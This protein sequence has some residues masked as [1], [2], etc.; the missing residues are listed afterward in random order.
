VTLRRPLRRICD[1]LPTAITATSVL[2]MSAPAAFAAEGSAGPSE[3]IFVLQLVAL[4]LVGRL[5][6]EAL[7]R[8]GQP[9]V[10][11]QLMAGLLL[12][13][14]LLGALFP[15]VQ[16]TLFPGAKEQKAMLDGMSQFGVLLILLLTGMETDLELVKKSG[17]ASI[18]ASIAGIIVPFA[19]GFALGEFLPDAMLPD[20]SKRLITSLFLGT[21]L[22]IA[23]VKIVATVVREMNF[24]RRTVG[25]VILGSAIVDDTIGWIIIAVI[26]GLA[27]KGHVDRLS[28]AQ[29]VIGTLVF[30]AFSLTIGRRI[31][32]FIIRW[33]NDTFVSELAVIT[34][35]LLIMGA[36]ALATHAIGVHSVLGAFVAGILV[37]ESPI[38]TKHIDEQLRGLIVAFFM[39]VFF[40]TAGL[41]ADL[42]VL[43]DPNLLML[44]VGLILI[45]TIGKFGGAFLGAEFGGLNRREALALATGMN[46]RGST[47]VIVATIGLSMGALSQDLF[48]MIVIMAVLTTLAM[49]PTLRWALAR[50]PMR[51]DEK[52]RLEREEQAAKG[53]VP[54]LE[55][56][57]V[58]VDDSANGRLAARVAGIVAGTTAMPTTM[59][60]VMPVKKKSNGKPAKADEKKEK[61]EAKQAADMAAQLLRDAAKQI[62]SAKAAKGQ[63]QELAK[64]LD[65]TVLSNKT[66]E[67]EVIAEEAEKGYDML[68]IGLLNTTVRGREFN[69]NVTELAAGFAGPIVIVE[70]REGHTKD[71]SDAG[72]SILVP[73]NGTGPSRRAAEVAIAI[74]RATRAPMTA[75]YVAPPK[76][77]GAKTRSHQ[78]VD[79]VLKDIVTLGESY[80]VEALA[81]VRAEKA[82]DEAILK[83]AA[84]RQ[85]NLIV[86]G[87]ERRPGAGLFLG[88]TATAVLEDSERSIVFVVS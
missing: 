2:L 64:E 51:K 83:E 25:Q 85:H 36:M 47:E 15:D 55:R 68:V 37:G 52:Q 35:I 41:G 26:F 77:D 69:T 87:V 9:A 75:L 38:L 57:L 27:L 80:D 70:A 18:S 4:L 62:K 3:A 81:A 31:V 16:H 32:S 24:L 72:L 49:P 58:A 23:S 50:V 60:H 21:A 40:G 11:G 30:M 19:C 12:G 22:S 10:M 61:E 34:A 73:V 86:M 65:V 1:H 33:V 14:S 56:L 74:A 84:K 43:K 20:P 5:L 71:A 66:A 48:T 39:P 76:Q 13:P 63:K 6:G 44:T 54:N 82:A 78:M 29:S 59:M 88:E 42:T 17:R 67:T 79:A 53:F 46:A 7:L 28:I 45:A 8:L